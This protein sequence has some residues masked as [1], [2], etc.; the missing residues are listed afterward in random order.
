[1][2]THPILVYGL[3]NVSVGIHVTVNIFTIQRLVIIEF[4]CSMINIKQC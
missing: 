4:H 2:H 1:M 3:Y